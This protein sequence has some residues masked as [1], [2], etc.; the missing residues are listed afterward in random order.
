MCFIKKNFKFSG[1]LFHLVRLINLEKV[2]ITV[3]F[4]LSWEYHGQD[5]LTHRT[6][7]FWLLQVLHRTDVKIM[8]WELYLAINQ[9]GALMGSYININ[10]IEN[11]LLSNTIL[12]KPNTT[13]WIIKVPPNICIIPEQGC[14]SC[15]QELSSKILTKFRN[16]KKQFFS[17]HIE[18]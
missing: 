8:Y 18:A 11:F 17:Q 3:M 12:V 10:Q 5:F 4:S 9:T 1:S 14:R 7:C 2:F 16:A 13:K 15:I 6:I